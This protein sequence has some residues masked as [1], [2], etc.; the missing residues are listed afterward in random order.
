MSRTKESFQVKME[1]MDSSEQNGPISASG[2]VSSTNG[3]PPTLVRSDSKAKTEEGCSGTGFLLKSY[4]D[5]LSNSSKVPLIRPRSRL[6]S[7]GV[8]FKQLIGFGLFFY[9]RQ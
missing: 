5:D 1:P 8:R 7:S 9:P 3:L 2:S 4:G 6:L